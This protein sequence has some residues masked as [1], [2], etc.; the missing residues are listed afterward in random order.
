MHAASCIKGE[1]TTFNKSAAISLAHNT[2][3]K[4]STSIA[5][6]VIS[7][8]C[9]TAVER[10]GPKLQINPA[11]TKRIPNKY[12]GPFCNKKGAQASHGDNFLREICAR[13]LLSRVD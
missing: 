11:S 10:K 7:G 2:Y 5:I 3:W 4:V 9:F 12:C 6:N 8:G 13:Y 1:V